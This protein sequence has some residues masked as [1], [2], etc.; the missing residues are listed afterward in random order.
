MK[1]FKDIVTDF[2]TACNQH[3]AI[4]AFAAGTIDKLDST[5]QNVEY[6][7]AFLRPLTSLGVVLNAQGVSGE[8]TL[9]FE[10]Y[11]LDVPKLTDTDVIKLMSQTEQYLYDVVAWFN[12]GT[13]QQDYEIN[14]NNI[15]PVNEGF[16]DRVT[17]WVANITVTTPYVLDYCNYPDLP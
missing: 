15:V 17:G 6:P 1:S 9:T 12:V 8:R 3:L 5:T 13:Q 4:H 14:L 11:M 7:L 16:N 10:L 2:E